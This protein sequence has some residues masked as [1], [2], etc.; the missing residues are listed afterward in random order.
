MRSI[1]RQTTQFSVFAGQVGRF[2]GRASNEFFQL[3][4][5]K[6]SPKATITCFLHPVCLIFWFKKAHALNALSTFLNTAPEIVNP[7]EWLLNSTAPLSN[8][9]GIDICGPGALP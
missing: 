4:R 6:L 1:L 7:V 5:L 9:A 2:T 8:G 3:Q